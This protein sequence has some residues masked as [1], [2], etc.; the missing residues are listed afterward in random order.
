MVV[1]H[2]VLGYFV[3]LITGL[4]DSMIHIPIVANL[5]KTRIGR[6]AFA[7]GILL[8]ITVAI[9]VSF[10]FA[11]LLHF[12]PFYKYIS[13]VLIFTLAITIY[14][15]LL[16]HKPK[17]KVEEKLKTKRPPVKT[18]KETEKQPSM[19]KKIK[20]ITFRRFVKLIGIGFVTAIATVIDDTIA[21]SSLFLKTYSVAPFVIIGIYFAVITQI[22]LIVRFSKY[23][24][25][26]PF[27]KEI[28]TIGLIILGI[29]VLFGVV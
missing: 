8:A 28:T 20:M 14:F 5:T 24:K 23:F 9:I 16:I 3:K 4:D 21:Y 22:I 27:K 15:D 13:A 18:L 19:I 7:I 29:L 17:Q 10:V 1:K 12:L 2:I 26:V 6:H 25:K 11:E